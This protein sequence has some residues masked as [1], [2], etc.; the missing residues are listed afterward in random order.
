M[1]I[2]ILRSREESDMAYEEQNKRV[3]E[4]ETRPKGRKKKERQSQQEEEKKEEGRKQGR[5]IEVYYEPVVS[6]TS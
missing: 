3:R 4:D 2:D 6:N 5:S 1:D